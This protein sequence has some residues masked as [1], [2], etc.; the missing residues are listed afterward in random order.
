MVQIQSY[1]QTKLFNVI[2]NL[3]FRWW[4]NI[5]PQY[6]LDVDHIIPVASKWSIICIIHHHSAMNIGRVKINTSLNL[7]MMRECTLQE[8]LCHQIMAKVNSNSLNLLL[9][10]TWYMTNFAFLNSFHFWHSWG[11]PHSDIS[12]DILLNLTNCKDNLTQFQTFS[13]A[14]TQYVYRQTVKIDLGESPRSPKKYGM[15]QMPSLN[16]KWLISSNISA[17]IGTASI[18]DGAN[19]IANE[20]ECV[21]LK[22]WRQCPMILIC[23]GVYSFEMAPVASVHLCTHLQQHQFQYFWNMKLITCLIIL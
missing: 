8:E 4:F 2:L 7:I 17:S 20:I 14:A 15:N 5:C 3:T 19:D 12:N 21:I 10:N 13:G 6:E 1:F 9:L 11:F 16:I 22:N 18:T 23:I